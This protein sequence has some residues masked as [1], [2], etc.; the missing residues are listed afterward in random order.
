MD[1]RVGNTKNLGALFGILAALGLPVPVP[2]SLGFKIAM[3]LNWLR[4]KL[5]GT[6][7]FQPIRICGYAMVDRLII[8][9]SMELVNSSVPRQDTKVKSTI[10]DILVPG[11]CCLPFRF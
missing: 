11:C 8:G 3:T 1:R 5:T 4:T 2:G 6:L 7:L 10:A 9:D